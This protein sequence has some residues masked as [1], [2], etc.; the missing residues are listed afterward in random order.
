MEDPTHPTVPNAGV[1]ALAA[2]FADIADAPVSVSAQP[3]ELPDRVILAMTTLASNSE[4]AAG[5]AMAP[6]L[7]VELARRML[8][9]NDVP[10]SLTE[11]LRFAFEEAFAAGLAGWN[12]VA[13]PAEQ[14]DTGYEAREVR[15]AGLEELEALGLDATPIALDVDGLV[16]PMALLMPPA[17]AQG[18]A[19][20]LQPA[21]EPEPAVAEPED[22]PTLTEAAPESEPEI[23]TI[24]E[25][26]AEAAPVAVALAEPEAE[27][28]AEPALEPAPEKDR[29]A[30]ARPP[31][32]SVA[33]S[34]HAEIILIDRDGTL[35]ELISRLLDDA[36]V[37][38]RRAQGSDLEGLNDGASVILLRPCGATLA[39]LTS[40][41]VLEFS[42]VAGL[43]LSAARSGSRSDH[44]PSPTCQSG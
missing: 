44:R 29:V 17:V 30:P 23:E 15:E 35:G 10:E 11:D 26:A 8:M 2:S 28:E 37:S 7:A 14:L 12:S 43:T 36:R 42:A 41:H 32:P 25:A 40:Q 4:Q 39:A 31:A 9:R 1:A 18:E 16:L 22:D 38:V 24:V 33:M 19:L 20:P 3:I 27:P 5:L 34:P 6:R 13:E 21:P